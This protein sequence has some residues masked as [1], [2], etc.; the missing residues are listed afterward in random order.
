[1]HTN[2]RSPIGIEDFECYA[3]LAR[4]LAAAAAAGL[5]VA[6]A[7]ADALAVPDCVFA[8]WPETPP[9]GNV[10]RARFFT[11]DPFVLRWQWR[12]VANAIVSVKAQLVGAGVALKGLT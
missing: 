5:R 9:V 6:P 11:E 2:G 8:G 3:L 12:R 10:P 7:D 1:M 4:L